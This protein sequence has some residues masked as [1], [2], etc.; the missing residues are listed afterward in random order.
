M[1][2]IRARIQRWG[3]V[4]VLRQHYIGCIAEWLRWARE[5]ADRAKRCIRDP[6]GAYEYARAAAREARI[7]IIRT[8][9]MIAL[10]H[11]RREA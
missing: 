9:S 4:E 11:P 7:A 5:D 10:N 6:D 1:E 3:V 8:E 2:P